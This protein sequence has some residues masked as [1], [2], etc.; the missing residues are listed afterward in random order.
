MD[1][2]FALVATAVALAG[3]WFAARRQITLCVAEVVD[4][5]VHVKRG[6]L[7]PG[8]LAD[9][10]DV[11]ARPAVP[12]ATLRIVRAGG[13]AELTVSGGVSAAQAQQL[14]NVIGSVPLARLI[15]GR[16]RRAR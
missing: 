9:L 7:A 12:R 2:A 10:A 16:T 5:R 1:F 14:R 6:G 13:L 8:I 15:N 3:L 11:L 4:G